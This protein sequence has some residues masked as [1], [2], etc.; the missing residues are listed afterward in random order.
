MLRLNPFRARALLWSPQDQGDSCRPREMFVHISKNIDLPDELLDQT[1]KFSGYRVLSCV[2]WT[3]LSL[4]W[5]LFNS[6]D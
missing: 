6:S 4:A 1:L 5:G 3:S 2:A